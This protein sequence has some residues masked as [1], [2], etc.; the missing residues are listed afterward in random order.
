M[1]KSNAEG[2]LSHSSHWGSFWARALDGEEGRL[3]IA[4][5]AGD[6]D[7]SPILG[8]FTDALRHRARIARPAVRSGWL[9]RGPGPDT[10]RGNDTY[11]EMS[12]DDVFDRL[13]NELGRV[14]DQYGPEAVFGGSYGW[15]SAGRFHHVQSQ[16]HRFLNIAL[17]GYVRSV[18][19]YSAGAATYLLPHVLGSTFEA[20]SRQNISWDQVVE[21]TDMVLA[22]G[23]MALK[24]SAIG[25][26]GISSHIERA[27]MLKAAARGARFIN[28]SPMRSDFPNEVG[29]EWIAPRPRTDV[30]MMIAMIYVLDADGLADRAFL[31]SHC[32]G[33]ERF[34]RYVRGESD[35]VAKSPEW[36]ASI[37]GL[38][39][40]VIENLARDAAK[41]RT[42]VTVS[43]SLQRAERGEQPVWAGVALACFLGQIGLPGGGFNY[44]L[45]TTGHTG[46]RLVDVPLPT[47]PQGR[48]GVDSF[49][50]CARIADM[51]LNPGGAFE[52]NGKELTYPTIKLVYWG[53]GNPFH[54]H[55]DLARLRQA[56]A[57]IDT[58]IVQDFAW[59]ST[60][61]H[62][63]I[64]LPATMSLERE[65]ICAAAADPRLV[66]MRRLAEPFA[67][68]KDDY[69]IF[70][71]LATRLGCEEAFTEGL[72]SEGWLRR[73]YETTREVLA[74]RGLSAP[75]FDAFRA[76]GELHLPLQ[77][78][79]GGILRA[80]RQDPN[81]NPLPTPSGKIELFSQTIDSFGYDDCPG[82]PCWLENC[83]ERPSGEYPLWLVANQP[84]TR[85]HSQLDFAAVSQESK[86]DGREKVRI[87][88]ADAAERGISQDDIV[89]LFN[90]RGICLAAADLTDDIA[91]G[92]INL[93]TG[94]WFD[95]DEKDGRIVCLHGNPNV[96][97]RDVG[98]S[99]LSQGSTGQLCCVNIARWTTQVPP[100]RA[101][102]P[103]PFADDNGSV[104]HT[105]RS[106]RE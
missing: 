76:A 88:P 48:N 46:R 44:A 1:T 4:P 56:F 79:D 23:G 34:L 93:S 68:A 72:D 39:A 81:T 37:T 61:R 97:T 3:Q 66:A 12:W 16:V 77:P 59:T 100:I 32:V 101:Y 7:P 29:A 15:S 53:G 92:T 26:G 27:S 18:G 96:L 85:L 14:K 58:L 74:A 33:S 75:D 20:N 69:D 31:E 51:L 24:N 86:V 9:K 38:S 47:L 89:Q 19:S 13:A 84:A 11:V 50:P 5:Y 6:P 87:N 43:H 78:D 40:H 22:F 98:T 102:D 71:E 104:D 17:G 60:A 99:R 91:P 105:S 103:P 106:G 55:Q 65:D 25:Q 82:H 52:F 2:W 45:G 94:A 54:H 28:I 80:F 49:I 90:E 21:H 64:V 95:P 57:S 8:N 36:A 41:G 30:A 63:D 62:A 35:G 10:N 73:L 83:M 70:R 67:E 42:L